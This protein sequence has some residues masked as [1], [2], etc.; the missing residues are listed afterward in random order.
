MVFDILGTVTSKKDILK[1][2]QKQPLLNQVFFTTGQRNNRDFFQTFNYKKFW[3]W[4]RTRPEL[5][6]VINIPINDSVGGPIEYTAI[7]G[8]PLG[9]N[10]RLKA[11]RFWKENFVREVMKSIEF[12][13]YLTGDGY[14]FKG[15]LT[16]KQIKRALLNFRKEANKLSRLN[17]RRLGFKEHTAL[18]NYLWMKAIQDEDLTSPKSFSYVASSTMQIKSNEFQILGYRQIASGKQQNYNKEE[19]I[20][21]ILNRL[22]GRVEGFSPIET[23]SAEMYLII[24]I[25][26]NMISF[27]E[28]GGHPS[29]VYSLP[30][31]KNIEDPAYERLINMLKEAKKV[32]NSNGSLVY[33][34]NLKVDDLGSSPKDMQYQDLYMWIVSNIAFAFQIPSTRIPYLL[35]GSGGA[36]NKGDSGGVSD[37][38]YW[39]TI[40]T[41]QTY[42]EDVYNSQLFEEL[43]FHIK[44]V[45]GNKQDKIRDTQALVQR[46]D[47][48]SKIQEV[49]KRQ[50]KKIKDK[51]I[52][53]ML[54]IPDD[55]IEDL[56]PEDIMKFDSLPM[57]RQ[58]QMNNM[59]T[60]RNEATVDR[61]NN[62]RESSTTNKEKELKTKQRQA[63]NDEL[64]YYMDYRQNEVLKKKS[65]LIDNLKKEFDNE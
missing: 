55:D 46:V 15:K 48:V 32:I 4:F 44:F 12:D 6:S 21:L 31:V 3:K 30:D 2:K 36:V 1:T 63:I 54:D 40:E 27:F 23:M 64:N 10:K 19:I 50:G 61:S 57:N 26:E 16:S 65:K 35:S 37:A 20:H 14:G 49:W 56:S 62:K 60:L 25:K 5:Y 38:G 18:S 43:G 39:R 9:R 58:N 28:N 41:Q 11:E 8:S 42:L 29:K 45:R 51:K 33:V 13:R 34:G 59:Q 53:Q 7:D 17:H 22:D 52:A 24:M 47:A